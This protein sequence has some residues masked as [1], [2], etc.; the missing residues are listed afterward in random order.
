MQDHSRQL[1]AG[2]Q[3]KAIVIL[4]FIVVSVMLI[5]GWIYFD[6]ACALLRDGDKQYAMHLGQSLALN[7]KYYLH[8]SDTTSLNNLVDD[9]LE[10]KNI[11]FVGILDSDGE[12]IASAHQKCRPEQWSG[13][14]NLPPSVFSIVQLEGNVL[15]L[16]M[17]VMLQ[18]MSLNFP[19]WLQI[20]TKPIITNSDLLQ[21][22]F[23][24]FFQN[25]SGILMSLS[26]MPPLFRFF[27]SPSWQRSM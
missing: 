1:H 13:I 2:L 23:L 17:P 27:S 11:R 21:M 6:N 22:T 7:A 24:T 15:T 3:V 14:I 16:A 9:L 8:E 10:F 25:L 19:A 18:K 5:G 20:S 4:T 26:P 12:L